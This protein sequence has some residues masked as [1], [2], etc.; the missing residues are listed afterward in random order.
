MF[1]ISRLACGSIV[2][3][4]SLC[5]LTGLSSTASAAEPTSTSILISGSAAGKRPADPAEEAALKNLEAA[6]LA[7]NV[8]AVRASLLTEDIVN[9]I[10]PE[11]DTALTLALRAES[12]RS[13]DALLASDKVDVTVRNRFG[14]SPLMLAVFKGNNAVFEE[15]LKRGARPDEKSGW[16]ALHYAA[17]QGNKAYV[18]RLLSLGADPNVRTNQGVTPLHMA[19]RIPARD[20]ILTLLRAGAYRDYCTTA[21][22]S[23]ADFARKAG[24]EELA[25]YLAVERCARPKVARR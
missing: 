21:G 24:D 25:T 2:A 8:S 9:R 6:I 22:K 11:G 1:R 3:L 17:A 12:R 5:L 13:V 15:L 23:P 18:E 7:D 14:E 4:A 20:V 10:L 16:S 19:A